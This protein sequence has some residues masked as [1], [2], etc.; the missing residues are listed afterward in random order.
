M[1]DYENPDVQLFLEQLIDEF[2][3]KDSFFR[4]KFSFT[5]LDPELKRKNSD[6]W[7]TAFGS[8]YHHLESALRERQRGIY[9]CNKHD[10]ESLQALFNAVSH[11]EIAKGMC[12]NFSHMITVDMTDWYRSQGAVKGGLAKAA[13][14]IPVKEQAVK[15]L[16]E[17]VPSNGGWKNRSIAAEA[18]VDKLWEFIESENQLGRKIDLKYEN[19]VTTL[20]QWAYKDEPLKAAFDHTVRMKKK[21]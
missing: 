5:S 18:I 20:K 11:L 15:L 10:C 7:H 16:Y 1:L 6:G 8:F 14:N 21:K 13:L 17:Y 12:I 4:A 9:L 3:S 2:T 19:L